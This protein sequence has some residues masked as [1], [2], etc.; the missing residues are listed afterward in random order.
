MAPLWEQVWA[1]STPEGD[2]GRRPRLPG[3]KDVFFKKTYINLGLGIYI[4]AEDGKHPK[5]KMESWAQPSD[6]MNSKD[7]YRADRLGML[8][9]GYK[10]PGSG[11]KGL[12]QQWQQEPGGPHPGFLH[13]FLLVLVCCKVCSLWGKKRAISPL[14]RTNF[15][16][17]NSQVPW[18]HSKHTPLREVAVCGMDVTAL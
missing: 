8:V 9:G 13:C 3:W 16:P 1:A 15:Y 10:T 4:L 7:N 5:A 18:P 11:A 2:E 12:Q 17:L 14:K 6:R